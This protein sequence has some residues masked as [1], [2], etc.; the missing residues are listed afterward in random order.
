MIVDHFADY[1]TMTYVFKGG[2]ETREQ[3]RKKLEKIKERERA[4]EKR[5]MELKNKLQEQ[6]TMRKEQDDG[7]VQQE[8]PPTSSDVAGNLLLVTPDDARATTN[9]RNQ[10]Q[11]SSD[12]VKDSGTTDTRN[13][14]EK[15]VQKE[16]FKEVSSKEVLV[17]EDLLRAT[18]FEE[19]LA[20]A[21]AGKAESCVVRGTCERLRHHSLSLA[22]L[23]HA[24]TERGQQN[25][26]DINHF[27]FI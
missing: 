26:L 14:A 4:I 19:K 20:E 11:S 3:L 23:V 12:E 13:S 1:M 6:A 16:E 25:F 8:S 17:G 21:H 10:Q 27:I 2:Y 22:R 5:E 18:H 24:E 9:N 15:G 7:N